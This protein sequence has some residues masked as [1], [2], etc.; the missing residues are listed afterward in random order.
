MQTGEPPMLDHVD[1]GT[2]RS[3]ERYFAWLAMTA[4]LVAVLGFLTSLLAYGTLPSGYYPAVTLVGV[5]LAY[6][7]YHIGRLS[8]RPPA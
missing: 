8:R 7:G 3:Q 5:A 4:V 1:P 6:C 2:D